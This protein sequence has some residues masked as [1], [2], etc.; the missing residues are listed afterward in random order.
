MARGPGVSQPWSR[1][2][3]NWPSTSQRPSGDQQP[4]GA[5]MHSTTLNTGGDLEKMESM[6]SSKNLDSDAERNPTGTDDWD[7]ECRGKEL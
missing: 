3:S 1:A 5:E 4:S 7:H 6:D 2:V